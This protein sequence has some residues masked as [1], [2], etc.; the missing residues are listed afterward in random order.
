MM[1]LELLDQFIETIYCFVFSKK[2]SVHARRR[3]RLEE[4][5]QR[6]EQGL[7]YQDGQDRFEMIVA[8]KDGK[9]K[10][11]PRTDPPLDVSYLF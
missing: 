7:T 6:Q 3:K 1:T 4:E 10:E 2:G 5:R 8:K 9:K 11:D